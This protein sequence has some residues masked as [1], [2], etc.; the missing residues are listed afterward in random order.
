M[1]QFNQLVGQST[2]RCPV[3]QNN[4][5]YQRDKNLLAV[6]CGGG[7]SAIAGKYILH[8]PPPQEK[9][10]RHITVN[11]LHSLNLCTLS[12][13]PGA[14]GL[15]RNIGRTKTGSWLQETRF[16]KGQK[17][18]NIFSE[19]F[20]L[21]FLFAFYLL[22]LGDFLTNLFKERFFFSLRLGK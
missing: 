6:Y 19:I 17:L 20:C 9:I 2:R 21:P 3:R 7:G 14:N 22:K 15:E 12:P 5:V 8:P 13:N 4:I 18:S 10:S 11:K 1:S 16:K